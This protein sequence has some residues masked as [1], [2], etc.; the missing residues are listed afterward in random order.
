MATDPYYQ[1]RLKK[2]RK[3]KKERKRVKRLSEEI[4][5]TSRLLIITIGALLIVSTIGFLYASSLKAGK[6]Y[7]LQQLQN[8]YEALQSDSREILSDLQEAQSIINLENSDEVQDMDD[9]QDNVTYVGDPGDLASS[10]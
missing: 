4:Q 7:T 1:K 10:H 9:P 5:S 6:G 2:S 8:E 3:A